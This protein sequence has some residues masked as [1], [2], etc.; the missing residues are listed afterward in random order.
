M[1]PGRT[2]RWADDLGA[3][4]EVSYGLQP[5]WDLL[6]R[7]F[8]LSATPPKISKNESR[9][10]RKATNPL[11]QPVFLILDE[12]AKIN[13]EELV[14][15]VDCALKDFLGRRRYVQVQWRV[16]FSCLGPVWIPHP[17]R[18]NRGPC[19]FVNLRTSRC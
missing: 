11:L 18:A 13:G 5:H 2:Y 19:F 10:P 8:S 3:H 14:Y 6:F 4:V 7:P 1:H 12:W 16:L 9:S 15:L 17:L